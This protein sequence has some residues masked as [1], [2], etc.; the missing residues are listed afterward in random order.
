MTYEEVTPRRC[1]NTRVQGSPGSMIGTDRIRHSCEQGV[2]GKLSKTVQRSLLRVCVKVSNLI[3]GVG[4][5][6][7][8]DRVMYNS[9]D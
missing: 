9:C 8:S 5:S 3:V 1:E 6:C 4:P 2:P 7:T